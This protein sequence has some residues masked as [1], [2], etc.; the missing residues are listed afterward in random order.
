M[1]TEFG[2]TNR[3]NWFDVGNCLEFILAD[4]IRSTGIEVENEPNSLRTD[5]YIKNYGKLSVKY[6]SSGN[7]KLHNSLGENKDMYMHPT[8]VIKPK[9][10]SYIW[11]IVER[12]RNSTKLL[13]EKCKRWVRT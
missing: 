7:I 1:L 4:W 13:L 9:K 10:I 5:L 11:R 2:T 6:S 12:K 8:L 3:C